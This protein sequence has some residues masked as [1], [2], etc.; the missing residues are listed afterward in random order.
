MSTLVASKLDVSQRAKGLQPH[1]T[2][3]GFK[4]VDVE[5]LRSSCHPV[6]CASR[7]QV[8]AFLPS[9][10]LWSPDALPP[11]PLL[12]TLAS[13]APPL[14]N[15]LD[16][17]SCSSAHLTVRLK[18]STSVP[19]A[20][21]G[22]AADTPAVGSTWSAADARFACHAGWHHEWKFVW[23]NKPGSFAA[24][25]MSGIEFK[26]SLGIKFSCSHGQNHCGRFCVKA[27]FVVVGSCKGAAFARLPF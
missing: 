11:L 22:A 16:P 2:Q 23:Q 21:P 19:A 5:Q 24:S 9:C 17:S 8:E 20:R 13:R 7:S 4:V 3:E 26:L 6:T 15:S 14:K 12:E 25:R 10:A 1:C 18:P 27:C